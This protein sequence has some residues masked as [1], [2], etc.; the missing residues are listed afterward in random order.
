M[1]KVYIL[2]DEVSFNELLKKYFEKENYEVKTF[3]TGQSAIAAIEDSPHVWILDIM[4]PDIDGFEVLS[5]IKKHDETTP[6][7]FMS[8]RDTDIDRVLGLEMG[9]DDYVAKPFLPKELVIRVSNLLKRT[10]PDTSDK[11]SL[12]YQEYSIDLDKRSVFRNNDK[13]KLTTKE[14]DLFVLLVNNLKHAFSREEIMNQIWGEDYYGFDRAVD[15]LM[16]RIRKKM[17]DLNIETIY[18]F[19]YRMN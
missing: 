16:R 5:E 4:L 17:P 7:I 19:G 11:G 14:Y 3:T 9:S 10:Y 12:V 18:G 15:D 8:A 13:I 6:V 1:Y 2:E